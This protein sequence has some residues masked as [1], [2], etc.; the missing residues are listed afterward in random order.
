MGRNSG[1]ASGTIAGAIENPW[2]NGQTGQRQS[3]VWTLGSGTASE[4]WYIALLSGAYAN[5]GILAGDLGVNP[6]AAEIELELSNV[7]NLT[8]LY[9]SLFDSSTYGWNFQSGPTDTGVGQ[10]LLNS[11]GEMIAWPNGGK[12][13]LR[14]QSAVMPVTNT[15]NLALTLFA[16]F[17]ASG[18]AGSATATIKLNY[19]AIRKSGVA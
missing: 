1:T 8:G 9:I 14:T 4:Q 16:N 3:L 13:T 17:D 12:I 6:I 15:S 10:H 5:F 18:A 7:A 19:L 2:S 11:S